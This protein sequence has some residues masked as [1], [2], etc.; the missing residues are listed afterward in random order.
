MKNYSIQELPDEADALAVAYSSGLQEGK[1]CRQ[2]VSI[3]T[4]DIHR[5]VISTGIHVF[6]GDIY[7]F[8]HM[9]E[10]ILKEKNT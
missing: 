3:T 2:W 1:K 5:C 9:L 4:D 7:Q 10:G 8:V 6:E